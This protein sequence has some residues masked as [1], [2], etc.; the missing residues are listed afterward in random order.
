M[1]A[2]NLIGGVIFS[3]IGVAA[4]IYGKKQA[5]YKP[6]VIGILLVA[7]PYFVQNAALLY[8]VGILLVLALF[9][10]RN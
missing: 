5:S 1:N 4:F 10:F 7:F 6:M 8:M 3:S 2:A 9:L